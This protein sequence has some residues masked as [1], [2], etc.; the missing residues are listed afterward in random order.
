MFN[1]EAVLVPSFILVIAIIF[2]SLLSLFLG[3]YFGKIFLP[4]IIANIIFSL[5]LLYVDHMFYGGNLLSIISILY[6]LAGLL[7]ILIL[8]LSILIDWKFNISW[9]YILYYAVIIYIYLQL[10]L[11]SRLIGRASGGA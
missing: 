7:S 11:L 2:I 8:Y 3:L 5:C 4:I 10:S 6:F 1:F 9:L